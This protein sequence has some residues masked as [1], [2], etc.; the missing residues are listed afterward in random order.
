MLNFIHNFKQQIKR[1]VGGALRNHTS[2]D[3]ERDSKPQLSIS[4]S[5]WGHPS[6]GE[7]GSGYRRVSIRWK[8]WPPSRGLFSSSTLPLAFASCV[9]QYFH[10]YFSLENFISYLMYSILCL[11]YVFLFPFFY[12]FMFCYLCFSHFLPLS[13]FFPFSRLSC[14]LCHF[15]P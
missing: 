1:K 14:S 2:C 11:S 3:R 8:S 9:F 7:C 6:R 4:A 10:F 13:S 5:P 15:L 12:W